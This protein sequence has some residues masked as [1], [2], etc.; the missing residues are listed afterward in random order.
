MLY[1]IILYI[2]ILIIII[3]FSYFVL[4]HIRFIMHIIHAMN[5]TCVNLRVTD[6]IRLIKMTFGPAV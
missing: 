3:F 4:S 5:Y 6:F 1:Y 2:C